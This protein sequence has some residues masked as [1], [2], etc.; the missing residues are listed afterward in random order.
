MDDPIRGEIWLA[1]LNPATGHEQS[2]RR[3]VL[4]I[5]DNIYNSGFS[6]LVVV[7]PLTKTHR[8]IPL[9]VKIEPPDGGVKTSSSILCD[10]VR[11]ISRSRLLD[12]W[13]RV[14]PDVLESVEDR[15]RILLKL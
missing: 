12:R 11:S 3:P 9:H 2:G 4:I 7:I 1:D 5:S 14:S 13:G 15:L 8:G 10:A 6:G